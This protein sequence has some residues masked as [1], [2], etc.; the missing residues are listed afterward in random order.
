MNASIRQFLKEAYEGQTT[1]A[2]SDFVEIPALSPN[3]DTKWQENGYLL[4]A[5]ETAATWGKTRF[6][7]GTFTVLTEEGKTPAL[8]FEIPATIPDQTES[9]FFYGHFDKQPE[10]TGW[11]CGRKPFIPSLEGK[12]LYGRGCAD[13][14]YSYYTALTIVQA[15]EAANL[16]HCRITGLIECSE[17]SGSFDFE[18]WLRKMLAKFGT[19]RLV[20]VLDGCTPDYE[21]LWS[22]VSFRGDITATLNVKVLNHGVHSG[23]ASG[24]VPDSFCIAR[25]LLDRVECSKTGDFLLDS[26]KVDIPQ[27]RLTQLKKTVDHLQDR[28]VTHFPWAGN[29]S[30]RNSDLFELILNQTWRAQMT[31]IGASGLPPVDCAGNAIRS[32]TSL[33][34]SLRIPPTLDAKKAAQIFK[35]TLT[36]N[37]PFN[38]TVSL[39]N[40]HA[41]QGWA[42]APEQEWFKV[43]L[44]RASHEI[45]Q[46]DPMFQCDGASIPIL[47]LMQEVF[48]VAQFFVTGVIGPNA[49]A[50][51][52]DECLHLDFLEKLAHVIAR[53]IEAIPNQK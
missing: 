8:F 28:F 17:E 4:Q 16:P 34:V 10:A 47:T 2:I 48:P 37:P 19:V 46:A 14:G 49:N 40:L 1:Q 39:D 7:N 9:V 18:F 50:H 33:R 22:T 52:P 35:Q 24:I 42:S 12:K 25:H 29:T 6:P 20:V 53:V 38:A 13:D 11:T 30:A 5:C 23:F 32:N 41:G 51:G 3:F 43:A 21:H 15:L 31:V 26:F 44:T 45:F 27:D 36:K